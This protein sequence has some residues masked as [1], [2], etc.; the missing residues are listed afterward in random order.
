MKS[1]KNIRSSFEIQAGWCAKL[2][3]PFTA[4]LLRGLG[5]NLDRTTKTGQRILDWVGV[6]DA[7]GD[8][9]ALRLAGALHMLVRA[10]R[11][12][13]LAALYPPN[14]MHSGAELNRAAMEAIAGADEEIYQWLDFAPQTN[15]VARAS[16]LFAG[17]GVIAGE[18]G[19]PLSIFELGASAGLNLMMDKF[20]YDLGGKAYG[21]RGSPVLLSP[22]WTGA[23]RS[24][25][26]PEIIAR[27]G[28]DLNPLDVT[29]P[30]H[31]AR[32]MAY[33]W[34][35][36][37]AR[38]ARAEAA[39]EIARADPPQLDKADA[40]D[41]VEAMIALSP[42]AGET[43][44]VTRVLF[45]SIAYQYFPDSVKSRISRRMEA[46]G[47]AATTD[48]PLAWLAFE[49]IEGLGPTLSL[50]LWR[51]DTDDGE[52]RVL[53]KAVNAHVHGV[54]WLGEE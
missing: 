28:C 6:P 38:L 52:T 16:V 53:A 35:D 40:A 19:L 14:Q 5:Q 41:W 50:R 46:M 39:I 42:Q 1:E 4:L 45:H 48:A 22:K 47:A 23:V 24:G 51:G 26:N 54:E 20:A 3:S 49:Q 21:V 30:A 2:G 12:P 37:E 34:P 17:M 15:E 29:N 33:V 44:G 43:N 25:T 7:S 18:T 36:Q 10:D 13:E 31:R 11:L 27:R 9:L 8:A 32:L